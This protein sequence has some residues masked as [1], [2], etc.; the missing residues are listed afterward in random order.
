MPLGKKP[1]GT[2]GYMGGL[3]SVPEA[4]MWSYGQMIQYNS[5]YLVEP[6]ECIYY[7][8]SSISFHSA[9]RNSLVDSMKGDWLLMLDTDH[10]FDPD[11]AARLLNV[12]NINNIDVITALY[13][14]R[15]HPHSPVIYQWTDKG[16]EAIG[17]WDRLDGPYLIPI[18]SS[19][20]GCLMIKR[21]VFE[22][23]KKEL[24]EGPF[25]IVH[26]YGED[27]SFFKRLK[28]LGIKAYCA[29]HIESH[30]I[31]IKQLSIDNDYDK[32]KAVLSPKLRIDN[33]H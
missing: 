25:D 33:G 1:I 2:I 6:N 12:M 3:M 9:A 30:H 14:Y 28:T 16:L 5:D 22:K 26:P 19:G 4:F 24:K 21:T 32:N 11:I 7:T 8:R 23:I 27:H 10:V 29:P 31:Q 17:D 15:T 13:Q 18:G 20:A